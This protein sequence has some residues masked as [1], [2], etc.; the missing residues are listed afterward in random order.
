MTRARTG[1]P[2]VPRRGAR[3]SGGALVVG[4]LALNA[5]ATV[6]DTL[7]WGWPG[8]IATGL[9]GLVLLAVLV[10]IVRRRRARAR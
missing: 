1:Q 3:P 5:V 2:R 7:I 4:Y 9:G 6:I 8:L 10:V